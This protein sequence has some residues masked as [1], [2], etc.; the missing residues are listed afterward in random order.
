MIATQVSSFFSNPNYRYDAIFSVRSARY[1]TI[2]IETERVVSRIS[3]LTNYLDLT[4][5]RLS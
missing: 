5:C 3:D 1:K 4:L 2:N